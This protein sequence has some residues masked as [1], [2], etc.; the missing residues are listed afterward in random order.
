[1]CANWEQKLQDKISQLEKDI[2]N[3]KQAFEDKCADYDAT[4]DDLDEFIA[5]NKELKQ[6]IAELESKETEKPKKYITVI[7]AKEINGQT[8]VTLDDFMSVV[9]ALQAETGT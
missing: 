1:M 4:L 2:A 5:E 6:R 7:V 3:Y 8:Y 9:N